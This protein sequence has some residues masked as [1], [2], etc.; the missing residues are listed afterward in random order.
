VP[1]TATQGWIDATVTALLMIAVVAIL[2]DSTRKWLSA[3]GGTAR[4]IGAEPASS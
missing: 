1:E 3:G 2:V 4:T